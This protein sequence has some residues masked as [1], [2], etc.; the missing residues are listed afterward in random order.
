[1]TRLTSRLVALERRT[2]AQEPYPEHRAGSD[3][4]PRSYRD[5]LGT[6]LPPDTRPVRLAPEAPPCP[7]RGWKD[8]PAFDVR[9][10]EEWGPR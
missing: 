8:E 6:F 10:R 7:R 3:D 9:I 1:M 2:P 5:G 4:R